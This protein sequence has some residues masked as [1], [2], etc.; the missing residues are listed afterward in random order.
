[1][2]QENIYFQVTLKF[3]LIPWN[4]GLLRVVW[5]VQDQLKNGKALVNSQSPTK[6]APAGEA[7]TSNHSLG[8]TFTV[9]RNSAHPA[10]NQHQ[11]N[12]IGVAR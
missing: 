6:T 3:I 4:K 12:D 5:I 2:A 1:M 10:A 8:S 7:P 9:C 11:A